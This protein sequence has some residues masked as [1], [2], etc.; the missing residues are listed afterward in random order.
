VCSIPP[1]SRTP[2][3]G[4]SS[5]VGALGHLGP[6]DATLDHGSQDLS[7]GAT[8]IGEG[9]CPDMPAVAGTI[10]AGD[11][12]PALEV[13]SEVETTVVVEAASSPTADEVVDPDPA[14][15]SS[16]PMAS[17]SSPQ[18]QVAT[19][20]ASAGANDN[21]MDEPKAVPGHPLLRALGK[22]PSMRRWASSAGRSIRR[23]TCYVE[24]AATSTTSISTS[25]YGPPCSRGG[26]P[27]R[28][29]WHR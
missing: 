25:C 18:P 13:E 5:P 17:P 3:S 27:L 10:A 19:A 12:S 14:T 16:S 24:R 29:Q 2:T 20:S 28:G 23:K 6:G 15:F 26:Q 8:Y 1:S 11:R 22:S 21:I 4:G 7:V 9:P